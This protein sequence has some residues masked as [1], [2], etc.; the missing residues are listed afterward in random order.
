MLASADCHNDLLI[1]CLHQRERG[2]LDPFGDFWLPQ[3]RTGG[4]VLQVLPVYIEEQFVGEGA[5]RRSLMLLE[6]AYRIE[7]A[8]PSD[9]KV[10]LTGADIEQA[11]A[12]GKIA[13]VLALEGAEGV[14]RDLDVL[15]TYFRVGVRMIAM[16][17]NRRTMM[18]DGIGERDTGGQLTSLGVEAVAE[19]ERLGVVVDISHLSEAG[20]W[21]VN[22]CANRPFVASHSSCR[23]LQDHPRNLTDAQLAA[24]RH[25]D[26]FVALNA[27]GPFLADEPTVQS[28]LDHAEH[29]MSILGAERVGLGMDF[30]QD[31][32]QQVNPILGGALV[33][34][35][36]IPFVD[37]LR[38]PADLAQVTAA[39][40]DRF[41]AE[42]A[43]W[44]ASGTLRH[45]LT[46][47]LPTGS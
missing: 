39:M 37:G 22:E 29:A 2:V 1:G 4:V 5:L 26:G 15:T 23:A 35:S 8:H 12:A 13:F 20:F 44:L 30:M 38:R 3:L 10:C 32:M 45:H 24:I 40:N 43:D 25:A 7:A 11:I 18:A 31:L 19:M 6:E 34:I 33:D 16:T 28:L 47:L 14:G 42:T 9:T 36:Q 46:R 17:W 21:H 41:D 27:F